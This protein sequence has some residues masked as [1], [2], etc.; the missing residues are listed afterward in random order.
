MIE[1]TELKAGRE[2]DALIAEKVMGL[3]VEWWNGEVY[4]ITVEEGHERSSS[5]VLPYS[6]NIAAAWEVVEKLDNR[7]VV[8]K[9]MG[10]LRFTINR[11]DD[12][13][14]ARFFSVGATADTA[15]LAICLAALQAVLA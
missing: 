8:A 3:T 2:L 13:Y 10:V 14:T 11:Y 7:N 6:D 12:G 4:S 15:P 1:T 5:H 9:E